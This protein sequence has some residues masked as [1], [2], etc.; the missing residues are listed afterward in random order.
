[1]EQM[2]EPLDLKL[3]ICKGQPMNFSQRR[4]A[5]KARPQDPKAR[6]CRSEDSGVGTSVGRE[7]N[8]HAEDRKLEHVSPTLSQNEQFPLESYFR[9]KMRQFSQWI[10]SKEKITGHQESPQQKA[11][12]MSTLLQHQDPVES[13]ATFGSDRPPEDHKLTW[14]GPRREAGTYTYLRPQS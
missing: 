11:K 5:M 14:E 9:K 3:T 4:S 10:N 7:E 13:V 1:M 8:P 6:K 12:F 2:Q